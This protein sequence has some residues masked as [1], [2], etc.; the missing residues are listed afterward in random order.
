MDDPFP[1]D[2][3]L[4]KSTLIN[5]LFE[6]KLYDLGAPRSLAND[7]SMNGNV[8]GRTVAIESKSAGECICDDLLC[9]RHTQLFVMRADIEENGVR[10][11]L[12]VVDTPGF[13]DFVNND[14]A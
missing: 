10:L 14:E 7:A 8:T 12:T 2:S 4:G 1:G 9:G 3:G 6:H 11:R 5:T 13:G